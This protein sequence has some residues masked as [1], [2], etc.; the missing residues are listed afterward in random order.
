MNEE[1]IDINSQINEIMKETVQ[2]GD[3]KKLDL[4]VSSFLT[5]YPIK[6]VTAFLNQCKSN[7]NSIV[8]TAHSSFYDRN[9]YYIKF[10]NSSFEIFIKALI[11]NPEGFSKMM[12]DFI[13]NTEYAMTAMNKVME[14]NIDIK[15]GL[16]RSNIVKMIDHMKQYLDIYDHDLK[17]LIACA[18][19]ICDLHHNKSYIEN[20]SKKKC[21]EVLSKAVKNG[22][23]VLLDDVYRHI[24]NSIAHGSYTIIDAKRKIKFVDDFK[25]KHW[26]KEFTYEQLMEIIFIPYLWMWAI[27]FSKNVLFIVTFENISTYYKKRK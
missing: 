4:I 21:K 26:E 6:T 23:D 20:M 3:F 24:R 12:S 13:E 10:K 22:D 11:K 16:N 25:G 7:L 14:T 15:S 19:L 17:E 8:N 27:S 1:F 18:C 2:S 9:E 5:K